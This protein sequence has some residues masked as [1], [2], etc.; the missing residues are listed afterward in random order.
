M[1]DSSR[2][3]LVVRQAGPGDADDIG[4]LLHN[5]NVEFD[6]PTP[7]PTVLAERIRRLMANGDT[8]VLLAGDGPDGLVVL[9]Y[10]SAIWTDALECWLAELY[11]ILERRGHGLGRAL[12]RAA[13]SDARQRGADRIELA[14]GSDAAV[15]SL[16]ESLG[17]SKGDAG[18]VTYFYQLELT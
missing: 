7:A 18:S 11:V 3:D 15:G 9:R 17:F 2:L 16:Y 14:T 10:R 13:I 6:E 12:V 1:T 4:R 8:A 5:F